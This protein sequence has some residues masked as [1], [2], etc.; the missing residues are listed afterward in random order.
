MKPVLPPASSLQVGAA[1][2]AVAL[3][4]GAGW[5]SRAVI[6]ERDSLI[7][8]AALDE[9]NKVQYAL[10]TELQASRLTMT[11]QS[12]ARLDQQAATQ[13]KEIQYVEKEVVRFRDRWRERACALPADWLQLYNAS[14]GLAPMP[15]AEPAR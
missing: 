10:L 11:E 12:S 14:L 1:A 8:Q 4:F 3:F 2:L 9:A 15:A 13:Q 7:Q 5:Q 6:A